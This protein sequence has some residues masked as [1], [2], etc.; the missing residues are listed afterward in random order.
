VDKSLLFLL[1][2]RVTKVTSSNNSENGTIAATCDIYSSSGYF[3]FRFFEQV[4]TELHYIGRFIMLK[5]EYRLFKSA[6]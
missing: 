6:E 4:Y 2:C 3:T 1:T 5:R